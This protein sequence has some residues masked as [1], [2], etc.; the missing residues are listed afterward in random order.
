MNDLKSIITQPVVKGLNNY[1]W[2]WV[3]LRCPHWQI[4]EKRHWFVIKM[5]YFTYCQLIL[6]R[7]PTWTASKKRKGLCSKVKLLRT[8]IMKSD[9]L[10]HNNCTIVLIY[11][12]SVLFHAFPRQSLW[13]R[14]RWAL[15][16]VGIDVVLKNGGH[17]IKYHDLQVFLYKDE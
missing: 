6:V 2:L 3:C 10:F 16:S 13:A 12:S 15:N 9:S 8:M 7:N 11:K 17:E 1:Q 5:D 4:N 14:S